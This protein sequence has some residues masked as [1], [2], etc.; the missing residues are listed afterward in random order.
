MPQMC[1]KLWRFWRIVPSH[2]GALQFSLA[3]QAFRKME[4]PGMDESKSSMVNDKVRGSQ[5]KCIYHDSTPH[6]NHPPQ[7][8]PRFLE[9]P[10]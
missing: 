2:Q 1:G 5:S 8:T 9:H 10:H 6:S 7:Q 3:F 4:K